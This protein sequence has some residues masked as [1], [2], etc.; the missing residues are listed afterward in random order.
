MF[1]AISLLHAGRSSMI[2]TAQDC[3]PA[4]YLLHVWMTDPTPYVTAVDSHRAHLPHALSDDIMPPVSEF[5][6]CMKCTC[7]T[8]NQPTWHPWETSTQPTWHPWQA[9][10]PTD[11]PDRHRLNWPDTLDRYGINRPD[12]PNRHRINGSD[13]LDRHRINRPDTPERYWLTCSNNHART[14]TVSYGYASRL[15]NFNI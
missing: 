10:Q 12:T 4:S 15:E 6:T 14:Q 11:T 9:N 7:C 1:H 8:A 2:T 3:G 13:T 5:E